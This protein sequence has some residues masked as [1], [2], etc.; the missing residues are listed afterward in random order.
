MTTRVRG[1]GLG[2]AI[3]KKIIE[4]HMGTIELRDRSGGGTVVAIALDPENIHLCNNLAAVLM[5]LH[6][7][8]EARALLLALTAR[9]PGEPALLCNLANATLSLGLQE[10]AERLARE[11]IALAPEATL[12]AGSIGAARLIVVAAADQ[13]CGTDIRPPMLAA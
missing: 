9:A 1:T 11:A 12:V 7:H 2:L 6:R 8:A 3:V 4:E 10:E 13:L 5:R